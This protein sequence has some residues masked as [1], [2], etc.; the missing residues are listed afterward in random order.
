MVVVPVVALVVAPVVALVV[1]PVVVVLTLHQTLIPHSASP[2]DT[3]MLMMMVP[4]TIPLP[5]LM[6]SSFCNLKPYAL[7]H[8]ILPWTKPTLIIMVQW[9]IFSM[10]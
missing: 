10:Q 2:L 3:I 9:K 7:S 6:S 1:A 5:R 4:A 8:L